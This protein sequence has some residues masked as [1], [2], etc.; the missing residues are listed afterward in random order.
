MTSLKKISCKGQC[1]FWTCFIL[2]FCFPKKHFRQKFWIKSIT[3]DIDMI[4]I[5]K[6]ENH[7]VTWWSSDQNQFST[8]KLIFAQWS[9]NKSVTAATLLPPNQLLK[10]KVSSTSVIEHL[11]FLLVYQVH[12]CSYFIPTSLCLL[13]ESKFLRWG[14]DS[15]L[16]Q[17]TVMQL[18]PLLTR[19]N[20][21]SSSTA[22]YG[23]CQF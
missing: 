17:K 4:I 6:F 10:W 1:F 23:T 13:I 7:H 2:V 18:L 15:T 14:K 19:S 16:K 11:W 3:G 5:W 22:G 8:M 12:W 20:F 21:C 9:L